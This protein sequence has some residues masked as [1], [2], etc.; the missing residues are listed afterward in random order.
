[1]ASRSYYGSSDAFDIR[2]YSD[3]ELYKLLDLDFDSITSCGDSDSS[4]SSSASI[5]QTKLV[6]LISK[7]A[8]FGAHDT[9][10]SNFKDMYLAIY[11]RFFPEN[12]N[13]EDHHH[14]HHQ[15]QEK[16]VE[17]F[18]DSTVSAAA[19]GGGGTTTSSDNH[20]S[21][22]ATT[23]ANAVVNAVANA[24]ATASSPF[25]GL[26]ATGANNQDDRYLENGGGGGGDDEDD[27]NGENGTDPEQDETGQEEGGGKNSNNLATTKNPQQIV[28]IEYVKGL[29]NPLLKETVQ[30]IINIDS[31]Y[32]NKS[33]Y[34]D[35]TNFTFNLSEILN[36]VVALKLY[37]L[38]IPYTWYVVGTAYGSNF[39]FLKSYLPGQDNLYNTYQIKIQPGN[40]TTDSLLA[41]INSSFQTDI[42]AKNADVDFGNMNPVTAATTNSPVIPLVKYAST[43]T[44]TNSLVTLSA[45]LKKSYGSVDY[46]LRFAD[47]VPIT[48]T[49][50]ASANSVP[51]SGYPPYSTTDLQN[52]I[53]SIRSYLGFYDQTINIYTVASKL[54][55]VDYT[56]TDSIIYSSTCPFFIVQFYSSGTEFSSLGASSS[57]NTNTTTTN[58]LV[59]DFGDCLAIRFH[60]QYLLW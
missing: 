19:G 13:D 17:G 47:D 46:A 38:H 16:D 50:S 2:H 5:V 3:K 57:S 22:T 1:M 10:A 18:A 60:S 11:R 29:L 48:A 34:P 9:E 32:R 30:R 24:A 8:S 49:A 44:N 41:A 55:S 21:N 4:S 51:V 39:F 52:R 35:S 36:N 56:R 37:S 54:F 26:F 59:F 27:E 28:G 25:S 14:H 6:A 40:Y 33:V 42:L 20:Y 45:S 53:F 7:Y 15:P 58:E 31:K 23:T 12:D 43:N